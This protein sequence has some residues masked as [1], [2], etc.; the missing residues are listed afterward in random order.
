MKIA[1]V[2]SDEPFKQSPTMLI[3]EVLRDF[4]DWSRLL[5]LHRWS[6]FLRDPTGEE[7]TCETKIFY[8]TLS[9][10]REV[11]KHGIFNETRITL[12]CANQFIRLEK[13]RCP[14]I[15]VQQLEP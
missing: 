10:G 9:H 6:E 2:L 5:G 11:Q 13:S 3:I 12:H 7:R 8:C 15:V 4:K 14:R 1:P